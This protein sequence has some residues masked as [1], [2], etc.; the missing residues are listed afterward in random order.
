ML[1]RV[2][3][4]RRYLR[5]PCFSRA[6]ERHRHLS[7]N[8]EGRRV[9]MPAN[10]NPAPAGNVAPPA[11]SFSDLPAFCRVTATLKPTGDSDIRIEV[12]LLVAG[13]NNKYRGRR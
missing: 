6:A 4:G 12:W 11:P 1:H 5:K 9:S 3:G 7:G 8:R 10:P 13:W 2:L